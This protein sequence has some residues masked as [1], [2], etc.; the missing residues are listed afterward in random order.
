M[1]GLFLYQS[2]EILFPFYSGASW[3]IGHAIHYSWQLGRAPKGSKTTHN[4]AFFNIYGPQIHVSSAFCIQVSIQVKSSL[5]AF[6]SQVS[7]VSQQRSPSWFA[8]PRFCDS[9][10]WVYSSS[11]NGLEGKMQNNNNNTIKT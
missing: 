9:K 3:C 7:W 6:K 1:K 10:S 11:M 4:I 8:S 2:L 5:Q